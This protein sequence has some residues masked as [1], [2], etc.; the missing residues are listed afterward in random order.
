M[1]FSKKT[2]FSRTGILA[3]QTG[4]SDLPKPIVNGMKIDFFKCI[5]YIF[6]WRNFTSNQ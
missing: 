2:L 3:C 4:M 6:S 1:T 5:P